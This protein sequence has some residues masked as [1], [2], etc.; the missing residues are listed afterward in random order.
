[1][2][3]FCRTGGRFGY[4]LAFL[5]FFAFSDLF[6]GT[7][8]T[9]RGCIPSVTAGVGTEAAAVALARDAHLDRLA[10]GGVA[11]E[12]LLGAAG[13]EGDGAVVP[14][15]PQGLRRPLRRAGRGR[16]GR[17]EPD[18]AGLLRRLLDQGEVGD[19]QL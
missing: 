9:I 19:G 4:F 3:W 2:R 16:A 13:D 5:A 7:P 12:R 1:M 6:F 18:E 8:P 15:V 10:G 17:G 11:G 14:D